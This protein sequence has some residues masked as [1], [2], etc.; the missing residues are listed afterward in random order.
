MLVDAKKNHFL[1]CVGV[2]PDESLRSLSK[3]HLKTSMKILSFSR[4]IRKEYLNEV[5]EGMMQV[6]TSV[7]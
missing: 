2:L 5:R 7:F 1:Y 6:L 4:M 3:N